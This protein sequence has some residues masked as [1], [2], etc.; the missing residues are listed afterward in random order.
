MEVVVPT[1]TP[2]PDPTA[3]WQTYR[4]EQ[5]G[6]E[7]R[8]PGDWKVGSSGNTVQLYTYQGEGVLIPRETDAKMEIGAERVK[9]I[10]NQEETELL[11]YGNNKVFEITRASVIG[12]GTTRIVYLESLD[13]DFLQIAFFFNHELYRNEFN[14]ILSTFKFIDSPIVT[15]EQCVEAGNPVMESFPEQCRTQD[16]V[17]F[18]NWQGA[19]QFCAQVI[20]PARNPQTGEV[21]DFPTPCD[22]PENWEPVSN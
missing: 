8:Y 9:E 3:D 13:N 5:Y 1:F 10:Y 20:T 6:F 21:R 7:F 22:V 18:V 15:F 2:R 14:Q 17:L 16:G 4:N 19:G 11:Y 12:P